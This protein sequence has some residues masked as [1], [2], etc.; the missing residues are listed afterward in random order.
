MRQFKVIA[1]SCSGKG[2]RI[3]SSGDVVDESGFPENT[4]D[5][6]VKNGFIQEVKSKEIKEE[7]KE[8]E[9]TEPS[10]TEGTTGKKSNKKK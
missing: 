5:E 6:L 8:V 1:L 2:K 3:Y 10:E 7:A 4:A 9:P